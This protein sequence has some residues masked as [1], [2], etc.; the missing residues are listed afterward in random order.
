MLNRRKFNPADYEPRRLA[1]C[2]LPPMIIIEYIK[3]STGKMYLRKLKIKNKISPSQIPR[4]VQTLLKKHSSYFGSGKISE[5]QLKKL[6]EKLMEQGTWPNRIIEP[7]IKE[8]SSLNILPGLSNSHFRMN[9]QLLM[10]KSMNV[11]ESK[12]NNLVGPLNRSEITEEKMNSSTVGQQV[13]GIT[14]R[15]LESQTLN[16]VQRNYKEDDQSS[17]KELETLEMPIQHQSFEENFDSDFDAGADEF[18]E[19]QS[20]NED[21]GFDEIDI[22]E[23]SQIFR[24]NKKFSK[25]ELNNFSNLELSELKGIDISKD[26][27][28]KINTRDVLKVKKRMDDQ[29]VKNNIPKDDLAFEYDKRAD[30]EAEQSN[31]WDDIDFDDENEF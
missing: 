14:Q 9:S 11:L 13:L 24:S 28:N 20:Q 3:P 30:F 23:N 31:E 19:K 8:T 5:S 12:L 17:Q 25:I 6:L 2:Y 1:L 16:K 29:F 10:E 15:S 21:D 4:L 7:P 27:L 18:S 22:G 26:D